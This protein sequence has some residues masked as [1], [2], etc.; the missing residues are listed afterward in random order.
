MGKKS[1]SVHADISKDIAIVG[2]SML[3]PGAKTLGEFWSNLVNGVD[4]ITDAPEGVIESFFFGATDNKTPDKFYCRRG[5]FTPHAVVD[6]VRYGIMPVTAEGSDPDQLISLMLAENALLD[7]GIPQKG[8]S[9]DKASIIIGRGNFAGLPQ[10]RGGGVVRYANEV[11]RIVHNALPGI[12]E[13]DLDKVKK[14]YQSFFGRYASD[15]ATSTIP[16]LAASA[17]SN[18]FDMHGPAY[19]IDGACA[20]GILALEQGIHLLR[21]GQSDIALIGAIHSTQN[22]VFWSAFTLMGALSYKGVIAPFSKDADGLVI[23]QG[24]GYLVI[25][26]LERAI[27]DE[28]RIYAVVKGTACGS[29]GGGHSVLVTDTDGQ[30]AVVK[31]AWQRAGMDPSVV[32][33]VEAHGTGTPVGDATEARTLARMFGDS[34]APQAYV[35]SVKSNIGHLMPAAGM[36]GLIKTALALYHRRIPPTLH[37]ENP[38]DALMASR[39]TPPQET[40]DWEESGLPLIAGVDAF[41]FGGI[42]SHAVMTAY[43]EPPKLH[44]SY[45][46]DRRKGYAPGLYVI[47]AA[48]KEALLEK[49]D[50]QQGKN[51][52]GPFIG[53]A[54]DRYRLVLFD[55]TEDRIQQAAQIVK[56]DKPWLGRSD[57]WYTNNPLILDGGKVAFMFP[58]WDANPP[59]EHDSIVDELNLTWPENQAPTSEEAERQYQELWSTYAEKTG[60]DETAAEGRSFAEDIIDRTNMAQLVDEALRKTGVRPDMYVGHS[61]GEWHAARAVGMIDESA[62]LMMDHFFFDPENTIPNE[63]MPDFHSVAINGTLSPEGRARLLA[64]PDVWLTN[65][66]CPSQILL[67]ALGTSLDALE[68]AAKDEHVFFQLLPF[69]SSIHTPMVNPVLGYLNEQLST[70]ELKEGDTPVWSSEERAVIKPDQTADKGFGHHFAEPVE[71]RKLVGDLYEREGVRVF[72]QIGGGSLPQFV[73]DTLSGRPCATV[74]SVVPGR[75]FSVDQLRRVHA[76]LFVEGGPADLDFMGVNPIYRTAKSIYFMP[77]GAP[78]VQD[79]PVLDELLKDYAPASERIA[80]PVPS[81]SPA[82]AEASTPV[83]PVEQAETA[84]PIPYNPYR[85]GT[86][87]LPPRGFTRGN[88]QPSA[89]PLVAASVSGQ[90]IGGAQSAPSSPAHFSPVPP[91]SPVLP[92]VPSSAPA[93]L[94]AEKPP[95]SPPAEKPPSRAGTRFEE[96]LEADLD[97]YPYL[98]D[99]SIVNQPVGWTNRDDIFP[100]IPLTMTMTLL[101]DIAK[102]HAPGQRVIK[103]T[104]VTAMDFINVT[105]PWSGVVQG[106]WRSEDVLSLTIPGKIM[107]AF[108]MGTEAPEVPTEWVEKAKEDVGEPRMEPIERE[109][110]YSDYAFHRDRFRSLIRSEKFGQNGFVNQITKREGMGSLLDQ[111]GQS[112][113]LFLHLYMENNQVSFP[114]RVNE[115]TFY[116][117]MDDDEGIFMNYVVIRTVTD[118][119]ITA[120]IVYLRDGKVWAIAR[121]WTNQR[122]GID[123]GLWLCVIKPQVNLLAVPLADDVYYA[124]YEGELPNRNSMIFLYLRYL[125]SSEKKVCSARATEEAQDDFVVGRIALKDALKAK[126]KTG[127][128]YVYPIEFDTR[129]DENGKPHVLWTDGHPIDPPIEVSLA[130]KD[131]KGVAILADHPVGIDIETIEDKEQSF[132]DLAFTDSEQELLRAQPDPNR[133]AIQFWVAKEAYGKMLGTGLGGDP[134]KHVVSGIDGDQLTVEGQRIITTE[135]G[136]CIIGWTA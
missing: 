89:R 15:T 23:G 77:I 80:A 28:D 129:Y 67:C 97:R 35:G 43:E 128:S 113:G 47:T 96:P 50:Y 127:D 84:A 100:V 16:N 114:V 136:G 41:G 68:Q 48:T 57:I 70:I 20:S 69:G 17:V 86:G 55:A 117:D 110:V 46:V 121:G 32:G 99:H 94:P 51:R 12:S 13:S 125:T 122:I 56:R 74:S 71:F 107:M 31:R 75:R 29:D 4:S 58:G 95:V 131:H 62:A 6:P 83:H 25:K 87:I 91:P 106:F 105:P 79:L 63:Y 103:M 11:V 119:F 93:P 92:A 130:H 118:S 76:M 115:L 78:L 27:R 101:A 111:M 26:T 104:Q 82:P 21:T 132:W 108:T 134:K 39:F 49:L 38:S 120:D 61:I 65:D 14:D 1:K 59:V 124:G 40:I 3:C 123:H 53:P 2:M 34:S 9:V 72:I 85:R 44:R 19:L 109:K 98:E 37:C 7:A 60:T 10:L 102:K 126:Y 36:A 18:H 45:A 112:V 135:R 42:D 22:A 5:G 116:Q 88:F 81:P 24:A 73:D 64:I 30:S 52:V 66:N 54:D 90:T 133:A 33:Y 8:I